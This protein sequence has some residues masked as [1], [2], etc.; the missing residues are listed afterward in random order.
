[1]RRLGNHPSIV[2]WSGNNENQVP[3]L[4]VPTPPP[5]VG[6]MLRVIYIIYMYTCMYI[7]AVNVKCPCRNIACNAKPVYVEGHKNQVYIPMQVA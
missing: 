7:A 2:L 5:Y 6:F 1:M 4:L 3:L